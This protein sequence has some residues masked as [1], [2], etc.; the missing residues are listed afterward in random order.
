MVIMLI[1]VLN[2]FYFLFSSN[3]F[4]RVSPIVSY[5]VDLAVL[6][7]VEIRGLVRL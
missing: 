4:D 5:K 7:A 2:I 6:A 3:L 1:S